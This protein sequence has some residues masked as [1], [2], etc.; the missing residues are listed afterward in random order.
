MQPDL[1]LASLQ[2]K[3]NEHD[4][5]SYARNSKH[6]KF[7]KRLVGAIDKDMHKFNKMADIYSNYKTELTYND[8]HITD[9][10][11]QGPKSH[12]NAHFTQV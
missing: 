3:L 11:H 8:A 10:R 12:H 7:G 1:S 5:P 9:K 2:Q 4:L 6:D